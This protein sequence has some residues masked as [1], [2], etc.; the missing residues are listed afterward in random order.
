M[1][2]VIQMQNKL[3]NALEMDK[4][5]FKIVS[6]SYPGSQGGGAVLPNPELGKAQPREYPDVIAM[7]PSETTVDVLLNESKG[8]FNKT[9]VD[10]DV[11]KILRYKNESAYK[12]AL[13]ETLVVA[14]V[15][16]SRKQLR[17]IVVG[18]SFGLNKETTWEP[19]NVDFVFV[20]KNR[21]QWY[22]LYNSKMSKIIKKTEGQTRF[23][24]VFKCNKSD[25]LSLF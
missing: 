10:R 5:G 4:G 23:P 3:A 2:T 17:N 15:I 1:N 16:D 7:P 24:Q 8:M 25:T 21:K 20:V 11:A 14:Q 18:V 9:E 12:S 19:G 22:I 6:V 13:K